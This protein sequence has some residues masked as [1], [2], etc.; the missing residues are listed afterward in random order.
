MPLT[1][2]LSVNGRQIGQVVVRNVGHPDSGD[3]PDTDDLRRYLVTDSSSG[4]IAHVEH[5]RSDG[6][7][8]LA[9]AALAQ[10]EMEGRS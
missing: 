1:I 8:A 3:H 7:V 6:A 2:D 10:L 4:R 9:A 5:R